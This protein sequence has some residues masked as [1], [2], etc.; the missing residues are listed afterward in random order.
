MIGLLNDK[1]F[2][3]NNGEK[4]FPWQQRFHNAEHMGG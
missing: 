2:E 4:A 1:V 3:R